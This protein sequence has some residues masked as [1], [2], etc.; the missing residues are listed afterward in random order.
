MGEEKSRKPTYPL[1]A[2]RPSHN[3]VT[4]TFCCPRQPP[5]FPVKPI[6]GLNPTQPGGFRSQED[7]LRSGRK[8]I[9]VHSNESVK[10][11]SHPS[12][13]DCFQAL[14]V[15]PWIFSSLLSGKDWR[16]KE[17]GVA[18]D[19]MVGWHHS[20]NGEESEQTLGDGEGLGSRACCNP[21]GH[22]EA[23]ATY[24]WTT[25]T[26]LLSYFLWD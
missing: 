25:K 1:T 14:L 8:T 21:E 23:D 4:K 12:K 17:K 3:K 5:A 16:Q 2:Y 19:E 15:K 24:S 13:L 20:L 26:T 11:N 18:E 7:N 9:Q 10:Q 6:L 22:K